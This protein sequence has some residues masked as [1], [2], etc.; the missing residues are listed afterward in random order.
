[1]FELNEISPVYISFKLGVAGCFVQAQSM[2]YGFPTISEAMKYM[3]EN[4]PICKMSS[5]QSII[6]TESN[7]I[8]NH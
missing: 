1:M 2:G 5:I 7:F 6:I 8:Y 3:E 4:Y